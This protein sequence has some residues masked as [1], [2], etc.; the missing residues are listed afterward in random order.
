MRNFFL[1]IQIK[2]FVHKLSM[3]VIPQF[4]TRHEKH[5]EICNM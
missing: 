2:I 1:V 3:E 4:V 5:E